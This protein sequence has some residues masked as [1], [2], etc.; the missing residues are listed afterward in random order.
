VVRDSSITRVYAS[1]LYENENGPKEMGNL[2]LLNGLRA[3]ALEARPPGRRS[4]VQSETQA[5]DA[6]AR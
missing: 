2:S 1:Y 6:A 3:L 4:S 5:Q